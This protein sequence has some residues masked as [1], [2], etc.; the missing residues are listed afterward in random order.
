M[1]LNAQ[2]YS[3][4]LTSMFLQVFVQM[5]ARQRCAC[6]GDPH[7]TVLH[8]QEDQLA[9]ALSVGRRGYLQ[10]AL[11]KQKVHGTKMHHLVIDASVGHG[12]IG[13]KRAKTASFFPG[14]K[15]RSCCPY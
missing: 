3:G 12:V 15:S 9:C 13:P 7:N 1:L 11:S 6:C 10:A 5:L 14:G 2:V 8:G 4:R